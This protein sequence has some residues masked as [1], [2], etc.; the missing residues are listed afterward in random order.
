MTNGEPHLGG[1]GGGGVLDGF[2][3][4]ILEVEG[5]AVVG[6]LVH[7][8]VRVEAHG[9]VELDGGAGVH[10]GDPIF[11]LQAFPRLHDVA[12]VAREEALGERVVAVLH[13]DEHIELG[14]IAWVD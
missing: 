1:A 8:G 9:D 3:N 4:T 14:P 6:V 11:L 10:D 2:R 7:V 13:L 12:D 5:D